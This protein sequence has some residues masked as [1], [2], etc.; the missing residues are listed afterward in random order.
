MTTN[1]FGLL[2]IRQEPMNEHMLKIHIPGFGVIHR[3]TGPDLYYH[4]DHP[5]DFRSTILEGSYIEE[6]LHPNGERTAQA[7]TKGDV[8]VVKAHHV[9]RLIEL[10]YGECWTRIEVLGPSTRKTGFYQYTH[11]QGML[12]R[13]HDSHEWA[14]AGDRVN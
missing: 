8:F 2:D 11:G 1:D 13:F 10:P 7:R 12:F 9:H 5:W 4:H 3:F 6:I 14:P